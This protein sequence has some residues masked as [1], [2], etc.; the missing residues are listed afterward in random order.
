[1]L[2]RQLQLV[3]VFALLDINRSF[4]V[5][6]TGPKLLIQHM[7]HCC[8]SVISGILVGPRPRGL[9]I[10]NKNA[11]LHDFHFAIPVNELGSAT[12]N[13]GRAQ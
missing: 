11:S 3:L 2:P 12:T 8:S 10:L 6:N 7:A 13:Q 1:M 9:T 5:P 4:P